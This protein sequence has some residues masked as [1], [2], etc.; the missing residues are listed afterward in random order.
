M[1]LFGMELYKEASYDLA[2]IEFKR[3]IY[4][5]RILAVEYPVQ[6]YVYDDKLCE[7]R[8]WIGMTH[9]QDG[10]YQQAVKEFL[11]AV[12]DLPYAETA[13]NCLFEAGRLM[14]IKYTKN[15][16]KAKIIADRSDFTV[17]RAGLNEIL[18][19]VE[20]EY[21]RSSFAA[22]AVFLNGCLYDFEKNYSE[23]AKTFRYLVKT[24]SENN[25]TA[26]AM[27]FLQKYQGK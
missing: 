7:A 8:F 20:S 19:R 25:K 24:F 27:E 14:F 1:F 5:M 4:Y 11:Q 17:E 21:P 22:D 12:T 16:L 9:Y 15:H 13:P 10:N 6:S 23:A 18:Q 2:L 26:A 3:F